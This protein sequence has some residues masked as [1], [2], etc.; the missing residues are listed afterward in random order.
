MNERMRYACML[1][2][3]LAAAGVAWALH[4]RSDRQ[5][6]PSRAS[7]ATFPAAIGE[8]RQADARTL[9]AGVS[10]ELAADDYLSR[11]FTAPN[12]ATVYLF[13]AWYGSQR[14]RRTFHS[15]Q[16]CLPGAGWTMADHRLFSPTGDPRKTINEYRIEHDGSRMI[17]LYW[18]H[19][20]G[21]MDASE[22][23][24]RLHTI[25]DAITRGRTDGALVRI[26]VP[27]D[28]EG[29]LEAFARQT[30]RDFAA[31]LLP[32]LPPYLPD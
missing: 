29:R 2:L 21:R 26:L 10:R 23:R 16:N 25:E 6:V 30:A 3:L 22:Y 28:K 8:W 24:G 31:R 17:A 4:A 13:I 5:V 27:M 32:L 9:G 1:A 14:H 19:G 11:T 18:Y 20:R 7:L 15:P 12:G